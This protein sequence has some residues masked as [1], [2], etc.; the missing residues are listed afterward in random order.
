MHDSLI[1][2]QWLVCLASLLLVPGY[3]RWL[4]VPQ[5]DSNPNEQ[6][7]SGNIS[8]TLDYGHHWYSGSFI[9]FFVHVR[10]LH[11]WLK[12]FW[13]AVNYTILLKT[14]RSTR[15]PPIKHSDI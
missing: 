12:K 15:G 5:P 6:E 10:D 9:C 11:F 8:C 13:R 1:W 14:S 4:M 7:D 3:F 2:G